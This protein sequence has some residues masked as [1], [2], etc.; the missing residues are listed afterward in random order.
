MVRAVLWIRHLAG[1]LLIHDRRQLDF[2]VLQ[3]VFEDAGNFIIFEGVD[4]GKP[5]LRRFLLLRPLLPLPSRLLW[6]LLLW[7]LLLLLRLQLKGLISINCISMC[8]TFPPWD[9]VLLWSTCR[10]LASFRLLPLKE[11]LSLLSPEFQVH[12]CIGWC[13]PHCF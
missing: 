4:F 9:E 10:R 3:Q 13:R 1:S 6:G 7:L 2:V 5:W 11:S 8:L 12:P